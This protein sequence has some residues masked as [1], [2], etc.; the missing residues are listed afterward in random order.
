[1]FVW[2]IVDV[3]VVDVMMMMMMMMI[4]ASYIMWPVS[5]VTPINDLPVC[6]MLYSITVEAM[7]RYVTL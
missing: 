7:L 5:V 2:G 1:M 4:P 3:V 6:M